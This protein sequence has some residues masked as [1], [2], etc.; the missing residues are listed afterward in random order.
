MKAAAVAE[1]T[2]LQS[3]ACLASRAIASPAHP[4]VGLFTDHRSIRSSFLPFVSPLPSVPD[5]A[6]LPR[7]DSFQGVPGPDLAL[8]LPFAGFTAQPC[9]HPEGPSQTPRGC[10][11]RPRPPT[12]LQTTWRGETSRPRRLESLSHQCQ[13]HITA[14]ART[15]GHRLGDLR[16]QGDLDRQRGPVGGGH[17]FWVQGFPSWSPMEPLHVPLMLDGGLRPSSVTPK[18]RRG[19]YLSW[20]MARGAQRG[21]MRHRAHRDRST[22]R[23]NNDSLRG[24]TPNATMISFS[25]AQP[26]TTVSTAPAS[27]NARGD[28]SC[29]PP[30]RP[31]LFEPEDEQSARRG[32]GFPRLQADTKPTKR[33]FPV[34]IPSHA[35]IAAV[36]IA[37]TP[38]EGGSGNVQ[39]TR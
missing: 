25:R 39:S 13:H 14:S 10:S 37:A 20:S 19:A 24:P 17:P 15:C 4:P 29:L 38:F 33:P 12:R 23:A 9:S 6:S 30:L 31:S 11:S 32:F 16:I 2:A 35:I 8:L 5:C 21:A 1:G 18:R 36:K 26:A 7:S 3:V 27:S 22:H 34:S 28:T